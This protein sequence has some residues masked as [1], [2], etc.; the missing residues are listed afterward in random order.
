MK[1]EFEQ[2]SDEFDENNTSYMREP[3]Y[4]L[5]ETDKDLELLDIDDEEK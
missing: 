4:N 3:E 2:F 1:R 5:I